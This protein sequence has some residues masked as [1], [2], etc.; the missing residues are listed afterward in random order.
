MKKNKLKDEHEVMIE[1]CDGDVAKL[2][3]DKLCD[4]LSNNTELVKRTNTGLEYFSLD[5][6]KSC[7]V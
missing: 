1:N 3:R 4:F 2:S 7:V 5:D 6:V